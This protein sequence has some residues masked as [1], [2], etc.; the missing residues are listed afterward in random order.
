MK[1]YNPVFYYMALA[2][3]MF[4]LGN[5]LYI[6]L[7]VFLKNIGASESY[8]GV[9]NNIDKVFIIIAAVSIGSLM[10]GR[11]RVS[12]LRVGYLFLAVAY[13]CYLLISSVTWGIIAIRLIH[14]IGFSFSMIIGTTIV[15]DIV[16]IEDATEAI[17]IYGITG[18][19]SNALSPFVGELLLSRGFSFQFIFLLSVVMVLI[20][21]FITFIMPRPS[22][23]DADP[24]TLAGNG[25]LF[26][27]KKPKYLLVSLA[28]IIFGGG[29]G[30]IITYLPNFIRT[31]TEYQFSYFFLIYIGV[32][33]VIRFTFIRIINRIHKKYLLMTVFAAGSL[34]F[35]LMNYLDSLTMLFMVSVLYGFTHGILYP[36]LNTVTVGLVERHERGMANALF[37]ACFTGGMMIFALSLGFLIDHTGTYLAAFNICSAAFATAIILI[38]II[39]ARYGA[40]DASAEAAP[41]IEMIEP[42]P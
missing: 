29:F 23:P 1:R 8:I 7:P 17:G 6:L 31:T 42:R 4:F 13:A 19:L 38:W 20:S 27:L 32:L 9:M 15:F 25:T 40:L 3:F 36:V 16:P 41:G 28:T 10:R 33:I 5:S 24:V 18:A 35:I 12:L 39:S 2:N 26:L 21:L 11:D 14:G 30:V 22:R 34:M 37:T